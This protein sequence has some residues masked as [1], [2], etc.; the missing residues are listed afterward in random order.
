MC[1]QY[2]ATA[3]KT[4]PV[5]IKPNYMQI[6]TETDASIV[7]EAVA[8]MYLKRAA[9]RLDREGATYGDA[10]AV[11]MVDELFG[12]PHHEEAPADLLRELA[13]LQGERSDG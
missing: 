3:T 4:D 1:G 12:T 6:T 7:L 5:S 13:A 9:I 10:V 8:R 11:R 2:K